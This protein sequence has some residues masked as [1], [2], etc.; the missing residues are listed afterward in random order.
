MDTM[1]E[2]NV[3]PQDSGIQST[4]EET[5]ALASRWARLGAAIIDGL[6][7]MVVTM[8]VMY[9]TGFDTVSSGMPPSWGYSFVIGLVGIAV[10]AAIN[11]KLLV[12]AG[13]TIGKRALGIK[14][15]SLNGE[16]PTLNEHILKRYGVYFL[17]GQVPSIG[18]LLT[19]INV[20]LIFGQ[21]KRCGHDLVAGT[22]VVSCESVD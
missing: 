13:Q 20:L 18:Q 3:T 19:L 1:D 2:N 10:F 4:A 15:V 12:S 14:I 7:I 6:I 16:L 9:L 8:P 21:E 22:K 5:A 17:L 11:G